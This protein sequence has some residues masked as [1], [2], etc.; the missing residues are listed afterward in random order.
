MLRNRMLMT[1]N[2]MLTV[3]LLQP[4]DQWEQFLY[5]LDDAVLLI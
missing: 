1:K 5:P 2:R 4:F 3:F